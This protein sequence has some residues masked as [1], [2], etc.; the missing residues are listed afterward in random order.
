[1]GKKT[2][3]IRKKVEALLDVNGITE[4][5]VNP[6]K[7]AKQ[8]GL[9]ILSK[10][11]DDDLSGFLFRDLKVQRAFIGVNQNHH[12]NRR[13]FTIAHEI[14]HFV[15]HNVEGF[16]FDSEN[17]NYLLKLRSK[18]SQLDDE[19]EER[20]A[21]EFAAE[22]LM[23]KRFVDKDVQGLDNSDLLFGEELPKLARK[24][25]VSVRALTYRLANLGHIKLAT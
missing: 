9:E 19:W 20:E 13:R 7:V 22:L 11:A 25:G 16:H 21:N 12:P 18:T 6:Q 24:Y 1:M 23:P 15:L 4:A 2:A 5:P 10:P 17:K 3:Q 8:L 14:G